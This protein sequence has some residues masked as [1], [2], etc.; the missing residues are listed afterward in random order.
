MS[1]LDTWKTTLKPEG[2][3]VILFPPQTT[4]IANQFKDKG[5]QIFKPT[6]DEFLT[7]L[8]ALTTSDYYDEYFIFIVENPENQTKSSDSNLPNPFTP[9]IWNGFFQSILAILLM[10]W[11][12]IHFHKID[13]QTTFAKIK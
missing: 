6:K 1:N 5:T 9:N 2:Y 7:K 10:V 3:E 8:Q 4:D 12:F 11:A 13:V